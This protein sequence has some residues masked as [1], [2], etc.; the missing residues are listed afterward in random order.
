MYENYIQYFTN[1]TKNVEKITG[2]IRV[3]GL[4]GLELR[5]HTSRQQRALPRADLVINAIRY[6]QL[7]FGI[8]FYCPNYT[9]PFFSDNPF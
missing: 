9:I 7:R 6:L 5:Q 3:G 8:I 4:H 2:N 1:L